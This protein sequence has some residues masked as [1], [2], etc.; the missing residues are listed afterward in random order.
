MNRRDFL[1][2][3]VGV[4]STVW[5]SQNLLYFCDAF[6]AEES[7]SLVNIH[8]GLES[9]S[10]TSQTFFSVQ[11]GISNLCEVVEYQTTQYIDYVIKKCRA[12]KSAG[13]MNY[14]NQFVKKMEVKQVNRQ[15]CRIRIYLS[16]K[17]P[18]SESRYALI[19]FNGGYQLKVDVGVFSAPTSVKERNLAVQES[20]LL[21]GPMDTR[22]TT[23]FLVLHHIGLTD[24]EV[25]A[26]QIHQWHLEN[27]WSG[28]G[29]HYVIHKNGSIERG[30]PREAVGAH[31]YQYNKQSIGIN[32]VGNFEEAVPTNEQIQTASMLI[33]ALYHVYDLSPNGSALFG[34]RDLNPTLCPG[35]SLYDLLPHIKDKAL[36]YWQK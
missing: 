28:I 21:F 24:M 33:A 6:A 30:R 23:D 12:G 25:S 18:L 11:F 17:V 16:G 26:A 13:H 19:P 14:N 31:C 10:N 35:Q 36:D 29:Y 1:Q 9:R 5:L 22:A 4:C 2:N 32:V 34:H 7:A 8:S 15:D 27:G 20:N 3:S